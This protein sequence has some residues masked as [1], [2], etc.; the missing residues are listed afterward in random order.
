MKKVYL[1]ALLLF[2]IVAVGQIVY[3]AQ[4]NLLASESVRAEEIK[5]VIEKIE[6]DNKILESEILSYS[7]LVV[8]ASRA[9][10]VGFEKPKE[11]ITL[12]NTNS[13]ALKHE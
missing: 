6:E 11:Y 7:S 13:I 3:L 2:V 12:K 8:V 9:A 10:E 1:L 5:S 4:S